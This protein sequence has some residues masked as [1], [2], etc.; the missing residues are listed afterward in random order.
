M[1]GATRSISVMHHRGPGTDTDTII[2]AN[3]ATRKPSSAY[4]V[5]SPILEQGA[6]MDVNGRSSAPQAPIGYSGGH[7]ASRTMLLVII[8]CASGLGSWSLIQTLTGVEAWDH[9]SY[10]IYGYPFLLF[11]SFLTAYLDS[12]RAWLWG[13]LPL[14][15]QSVYIFSGMLYAAV[16]LPLT[17]ALYIALFIPGILSAV[18]GVALRKRREVQKT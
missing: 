8:A 16:V 2:L 14:G 6:T 10:W 7:N 4:Y 13:V 5:I 3:N 18:G 9:Y 17:I 15:S 11:V 1:I 12:R